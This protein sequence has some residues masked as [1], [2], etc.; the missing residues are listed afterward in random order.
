MDKS[1]Q[2]YTIPQQGANSM[3]KKDKPAACSYS[4]H[5]DHGADSFAFFSCRFVAAVVWHRTFHQNVCS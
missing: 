5:L 2:N 4:C 1:G 3:M